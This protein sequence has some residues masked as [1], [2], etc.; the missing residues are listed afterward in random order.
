MSAWMFLT[1]SGYFLLSIPR[2][3]GFLD[4]EVL[5][6]KFNT[7][8][9]LCDEQ[10]SKQPHYDFGLRNILSVLRTAGAVRRDNPDKREDFLLQRTLKDMNMSK[11]VSDDG[12]L[13]TSLIND[14]F[15]MSRSE[16]AEH[17]LVSE[18]IK[19]VTLEMGLQ[20]HDP[21][22]EKVIQLYE[23]SLVRHGIMVIGPA[24]TGKTMIYE[25]LLRALSL[26]ERPHRAY[27]MNPKAITDKE[28]RMGVCC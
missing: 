9:R 26:V 12:Q 17:P 15:S 6:H 19:K 10:L 16:R 18:T 20:V 5:S 8:Y 3:Q 25:V 28:V 13:L 7:L 22:F 27:R 23:T 11:L 4:Y 24:G 1:W 2:E 21:I 14:L